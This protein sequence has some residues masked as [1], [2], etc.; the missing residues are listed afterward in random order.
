MHQEESLGLT[1][2][3]M[4]AGPQLSTQLYVPVPALLKGEWKEGGSKGE[5]REKEGGRQDK[6]P[7]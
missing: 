7:T 3:F 6:Q 2:S 4:M 5:G 1:L